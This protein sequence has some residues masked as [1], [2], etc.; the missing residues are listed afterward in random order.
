M[1]CMNLLTP[2]LNYGLT[3][4]S[5]IN[6]ICYNCGV[7]Y[8]HNNAGFQ[9]PKTGQA[10]V[11]IEVARNGGLSSREYVQLELKER[12]KSSETYCVKFYV[13]LANFSKGY[14]RPLVVYFVRVEGEEGVVVRRFLKE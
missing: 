8:H 4:S 1:A 11:G 9:F 6:R 14:V 7:P 5:S 3:S 12:L 10:Y 13:T 2:P